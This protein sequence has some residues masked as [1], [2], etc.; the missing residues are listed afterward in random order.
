MH[1]TLLHPLLP[2]RAILLTPQFSLTLQGP[3]YC[4]DLHRRS[5]GISQRYLDPDNVE[6]RDPD[7]CCIRIRRGQQ[8]LC[9][10]A[11]TSDVQ[12]IDTAQYELKTDA[13][14]LK[15]CLSYPTYSLGGHSS[16]CYDGLCTIRDARMYRARSLDC[17]MY[18]SPLVSPI[19]SLLLAIVM[20]KL[21]Y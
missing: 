1:A 10:S 5:P 20:T 12:K 21:L 6:K 7:R 15:W 11:A 9:P 4:R 14:L 19:S 2:S 17:Y 16:Q 3:Y 13:T 18:K 8:R